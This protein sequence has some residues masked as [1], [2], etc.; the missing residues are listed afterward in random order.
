MLLYKVDIQFKPGNLPDLVIQELTNLDN[1]EILTFSQ[2]FEDPGSFY[3]RLEFFGNP[4][5]REKLESILNNNNIVFKF[6]PGEQIFTERM[7]EQA[8]TRSLHHRM[9]LALTSEKTIHYYIDSKTK[10]D[11]GLKALTNNRIGLFSDGKK[12]SIPSTVVTLLERDAFLLNKFAHLYA[13]PLWINTDH[14]E[15]LVKGIISLAN[16]FQ[17]IRMSSMNLDN[18]LEI[19]ERIQK[20]LPIPVVH[21]DYIETAILIAAS[22]KNI[23]PDEK[24]Q[25]S[26]KNIAILGVQTSSMGLL[27]ILLTQSPDRVTGVDTNFRQLSLFEKRGGMA[28][29]IDNVY[30]NAQIIVIMPDFGSRLDERKFHPEQIILN[31]SPDALPVKNIPESLK[32]SIF[33]GY[34]PHPAC[35]LPG[36]ILAIQHAGIT[37]IEMDH[38][39][40]LLDTLKKDDSTPSIL[41]LPTK[42]LITR[43]KSALI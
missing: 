19:F 3:Y 24:N 28:S 14:D 32:N 33:T 40:K 1:I 9:A 43:Q 27:D 42:E 30:N 31:L 22:L 26:K 37:K 25:F 29:S 21:G 7:V 34:A 17:V 4:E 36:L 16:N 5:I 18:S 35:I 12:L 38:Q 20:S 11:S 15:D 2:L 6:K 41:P 10:D 8:P 39:L 13:D 23:I